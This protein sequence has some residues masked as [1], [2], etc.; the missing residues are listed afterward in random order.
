MFCSMTFNFSEIVKNS[1]QR[2]FLIFTQVWLQPVKE[3][4]NLQVLNP[5]H[6]GIVQNSIVNKTNGYML[7]Q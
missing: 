6:T 3:Q 7:G 5:S 1:V 2:E 4:Q